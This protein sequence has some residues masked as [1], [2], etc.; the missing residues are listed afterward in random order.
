MY[1][2]ITLSFKRR[3]THKLITFWFASAINSNV[4]DLSLLKA[5][6]ILKSLLLMFYMMKI[7]LIGNCFL[8]D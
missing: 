3:N 4:R 7:V 5:P 1:L 8:R 6:A 2:I